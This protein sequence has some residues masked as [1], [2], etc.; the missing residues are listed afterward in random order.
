[1]F[2]YKLNDAWEV[3]I[4]EI[5]TLSSENSGFGLSCNYLVVK[6]YCNKYELDVIETFKIIKHIVSS[7]MAK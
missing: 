2:S 7:V 3:M 4:Y 5:F 1:M 6:D